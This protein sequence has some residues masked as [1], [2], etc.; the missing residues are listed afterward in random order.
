MGRRR[1][2]L[3]LML[4]A[5]API[6]SVEAQPQEGN[7]VYAGLEAL[8][9]KRVLLLSD[10]RRF[11]VTNEVWARYGRAIQE[12]RKG[13]PFVFTHS[14]S[15]LLSVGKEGGDAVKVD[16]DRRIR[17]TGKFKEMRE[18]KNGR[19]W[20]VLDSGR[21]EV[22]A[23][24]FFKDPRKAGL[25]FDLRKGADIIYF[26]VRAQVVDLQ[27]GRLGAEELPEVTR[28]LEHTKSGDRV[29]VQLK[30]GSL[31]VFY[32]VKRVQAHRVVLNPHVPKT[33]PPKFEGKV[34]LWRKDIAL[35]VNPEGTK[36]LQ[37]AGGPGKNGGNGGNGVGSWPEE[38]EIGDTIGIDF[39]KGQLT[40]QDDTRYRWKIWKSG[41]WGEEIEGA[42]ADVEQ[43][44]PVEL[45]RQESVI[46]EGGKL[47]VRINRMRKG[48]DG[49]VFRV[50]L[51]HTVKPVIL[52]DLKIRFSLGD[53]ALGPDDP[54][55]AT[56]S[57]IVE[58]PMF[59]GNKRVVIEHKVQG[60]KYRDGRAEVSVYD[61]NIVA[62][63]SRDARQHI[64]EAIYRAQK[65]IEFAN[66]YVAAGEN[67]D[68]R[69]AHLLLTRY[70][71]ESNAIMRR[72]QLDGL[73]AFGQVA[74]KM[75]LDELIGLDRHLEI[76]KLAA[77]DTLLQTPLPQSRKAVAYKRQMIE[78][79]PLLPGGL[80][81]ENGQRLFDAYSQRDDLQD[82]VERAFKA[83]PR[84]AVTSLLGIATKIDTQAANNNA[85]RIRAEGAAKL[86]RSLGKSILPA[87]YAELKKE[88]IDPKPCKEVFDRTNQAGEA[89]RLGQ[90]MLI[91]EYMRQQE[92]VWSEM[93]DKARAHARDKEWDKAV[94]LVRQV[95]S[96]KSSHEE[97]LE[98]K[99][100]LLVQKA[101][102]H[103]ENG[104]RGLAAV[105][106]EEALPEL[107]L[108]AKPKVA[109]HMAELLILAASEDVEQVSMRT[110]PHPAAGLVRAAK[111]NEALPGKE[112]VRG[113]MELTIGESQKAYVLKSCVKAG[114]KNRFL[115]SESV[116]P[117][118]AIQENLERAKSYSVPLEAR[119]NEVFGRLSA[120]EA[121]A[122]YEAGNYQAA[123]AHFE[124]AALYAPTD[125]RLSLKTKCWLKANTGPLVAVAGV[126]AFAIGI[127]VMQAFARPKK[128][129]FSGDYKH[130]GSERSALER[131]ID[132]PEED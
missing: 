51:N 17:V 18:E 126:V 86:L 130:Y 29:H 49:L 82:A 62:I 75:I 3:P 89:I 21:E 67:G 28:I 100:T 111:L 122:K 25:L 93:V 116:T 108:Q 119:A 40:W 65:P 7:G 37:A 31:P 47:E 124:D 72:Y 44:R 56:E 99:P 45:Y 114:Q 2:L 20:L 94:A 127:A 69:I 8:A 70:L 78:V 35:F 125:P 115:I 91:E 90:N 106:F 13:E 1:F 80:R 57:V 24:S 112:S 53:M 74:I 71:F 105:A 128:V 42:K 61:K 66:V 33:E 39:R 23:K 5:F 48:R 22:I 85:D 64:L 38:V 19:V 63:K 129:A 96:E 54:V 132:I 102:D 46:L 92:K 52:V 16:S 11:D 110:H 121:K 58:R 60:N 14:G 73:V 12:L 4:F 95:L 55:Q 97:A 6:A 88:G 10:K 41:V 98:L 104:E 131:D 84:D 109:E 36:R 32:R 26:T 76:T 101:V 117:F 34:T 107:T 123:L 77:K 59:A 15:V 50:E 87:L 103:R 83:R 43:V 118:K 113:W 27:R 120:R 68:T 79:L 30:K 81:G 9:N